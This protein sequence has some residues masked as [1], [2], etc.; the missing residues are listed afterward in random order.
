MHGGDWVAEVLKAQGVRFI[1]TLTGGHISPILV[2][3][4]QRG[5][6]VV[7]VRH[8]ANAVFAADA[9]AR[10]T[11]VPG[12]A[13][14]TAGPGVTNTITA[15]KN[16]QMAQSPLIVIGGAAATALKGR[17]ALQD[18]P[19]LPLF[20]SI[21]KWS[22]GVTRVK[23]IV[24]ALEQ[25]FREAQSGVPG[26][27][28]LELPIDLL[29]D[30]QLVR[31]WYIGKSGGKGL[32]AKAVQQYLKFHLYRLFAGSEEMAAGPP[33]R[34]RPPQPDGRQ[35]A[36]AAAKL[37]WAKRPLLLVGSQALFD[38]AAVDEVAAAVT[39]LGVPVY[40]SSM[41]RGLLGVDHPLQMRHKRRNAL[42]DADLVILAGVPCDFRLDY[43]NHIRRGAAYISANRSRED[44]YKNR[45]PDV[46]ILGDPGLFLRQ[47]AAHF[48]AEARWT[49]WRETLRQRNEARAAEIRRQ[50]LQ[51]T[52]HINPLHLCMEMAKAQ[53]EDTI[54]V[55]DGGDFVG[56]AS[57]ILDPPGPLT[58]LDPGPFGTLGVGAGFA[59]G[60]KLARPEANVW[61][62]YGDG[63]AGYSLMEFD[64]FTRHETPVIAVVGNDAGWS[65][66]AREQVEILED[67]VA[68]V[69]ARTDYHEAAAGFGGAGLRVSDPELAPDV[70]AE[71]RQTAA[72]GRPVLVNA[73]LGESDF[74]KGS[75]SV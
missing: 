45:R 70:L 14:V 64:T 36:Q 56:A 21:V 35:V 18:I 52:G 48:V 50:A 37:R 33:I 46:P 66:I 22:K 28:F 20:Q 15:V 57:Y 53:D 13:V 16:A 51:P 10:L 3:C 39:R 58:W 74:R 34:P 43:G 73:I 8:E 6:R 25:A 40:L 59:L 55:A 68:T 63:S 62:I 19:Q 42:K 7:D 31:D 4:K 23:D 61:I 75:I 1:F 60:A 65:Q 24:P 2:G 11:G 5:V 54:L 67:D 26:P 17:G 49:E 32:A 38:V 71:A 44:L 47:L 72:A 12:V 9:V 41:A 69:L 30:E 27:V 29:Y